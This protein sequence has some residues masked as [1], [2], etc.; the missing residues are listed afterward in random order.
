M[1][2]RKRRARRRRGQHV[3]VS[4]P[5]RRPGPVDGHLQ[6]SCREV[7]G[8]HRPRDGRQ[9][10]GPPESDGG[11][12]PE[13]EPETGPGARIRQTDEDRVEPAGA[14][15]DDPPFDVRVDVD[16]G[17]VVTVVVTVTVTRVADRGTIVRTRVS[18]GF[19]LGFDSIAWPSAM[20][21][22]KIAAAR[23]ARRTARSTGRRRRLRRAARDLASTVTAGSRAPL[24]RRGGTRHRWQGMPCAPS[25][26]VYPAR[27]WHDAPSSPSRRRRLRA[28]RA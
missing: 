13:H 14:V 5:V 22:T 24:A 1:T 23:A 27:R 26:G 7:G 10:P 17:S 9:K 15:V 4:E 12:E 6:P 19:G 8:E 2:G 28:P 11:C 3:D 18:A 20:P 16:Q 25:R 21:S